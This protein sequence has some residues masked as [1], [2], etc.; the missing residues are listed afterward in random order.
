MVERFSSVMQLLETMEERKASDLVLKAGA[1]PMI[2]LYGELEPINSTK[3]LNSKDVESY[4]KEIVKEEDLDVLYQEKELDTAYKTEKGARFRINIFKQRGSLGIVFRFI[5]PKISTI[6][7]LKLPEITKNL[8]NRPRGLLLITGPGGCGKSSTQAAMLNYRNQE[9]ECHI[10]TIEDP[11][12]FI[13]KNDRAIVTQR[14]IGR[15]TLCFSNALKHVLRQDPDVILIGEM[16]DLETI[17]LAITGAETGH[18]VLGTLHT[19]SAVQTIDRV[20]DVFPVY[21]QKQIRMQLSV[22]LVGVIC[23]ILLNRADGKGRVAAFEIM[24][25]TTAIKNLIREGKTHQLAQVLQTGS[26]QGMMTMN[27]SLMRLVRKEIITKEEAYSQSPNPLE[28]R[29]ML[30][31]KI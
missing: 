3:K 15:D 10:V 31:G 4:I 25:A 5:P 22:N 24:I 23:Q 27:A 29:Q 28:L 20:I 16:R 18:L 14:Q 2:R 17:A 21:Q 12:E 7:D 19:S 13:H 30:Q 26:S 9:D 1:P 11:I 8:A 6:E